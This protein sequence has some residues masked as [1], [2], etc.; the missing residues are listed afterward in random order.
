MAQ[1]MLDA[2]VLGEFVSYFGNFV[3]VDSLTYY[4][5]LVATNVREFNLGLS[6]GL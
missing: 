2:N 1:Y 3:S 6:H 5:I 4:I